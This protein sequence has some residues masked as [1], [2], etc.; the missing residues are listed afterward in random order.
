MKKLLGVTVLLALFIA[1]VPVHAN[2]AF[3][4][5][6]DP[7]T[8][9]GPFQTGL[10]NGCEQ[11]SFRNANVGA[12]GAYALAERWYSF[13]T[14]STVVGHETV[15][16]IWLARNSAQVGFAVVDIL[17]A[18]RPLLDD[19][20]SLI[21]YLDPAWSPN[22]KY[23]A[24][25]QSDGTLTSSSIYIQEYMVSTTSSVAATAVGSP[26]LVVAAAPGVINRSPD[27]K[28]TGA[29]ST[30][31]ALCYASNAAGPSFDIW[32][33]AVDPVAHTVGVPA[34]ATTLDTKGEINPSWG[35]G[36]QIAYATNKFGRNVIEIIDMDDMSVRLAETNFA[37]VSHNNPSWTSD[38]ASILYDA[39]QG[40]D[41]N[42]N[43]DIWKLDLTTQAKCDIFFDFRGDADPDV[44]AQTNTTPDGINYNVFLTSTQ[45]A[46]FGLCVWRGN[47]LACAPPL[48]L[49]VNISPTTLNLSSSGQNFTVTLTS[50]PE[51]QAVGIVAAVDLDEVGN[52]IPAGFEGIKNRNTTIVSP[53]F[54]GTKLADSEANG[55]PFGGPIYNRSNGSNLSV[56]MTFGRKPIAAKLAA[57]GIVNQTIFCPVTAYS[58]LR[59]RQLVGTG[60]LHVSSNNAA[61]Q[62]IRMEQNS[63]NPFNPVTKIRFAVAKPGF[64]NV[65]IY[66]VRGELV[67]TV[68][69]GNYPT[70]SHEATWD[71]STRSGAKAATGI[72]FAKASVGDGKGGEITSD[73]VKMVMVK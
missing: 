45:G 12:N 3:R 72:Y 52:G 39:P 63:P 73:F 27:W 53:T 70:G 26:L 67:K 31:M 18:R 50:P 13:S 24:Y 42:Q 47:P 71:G 16:S 48:Q 51:T 55:S 20:A 65:R 44:S 56:D 10:A 37:S 1:L 38:G 21:S 69:S 30:G 29:D 9:G 17:D 7:L 54:L 15:R 34:R 68:A 59:G 41:V 25:V 23:L 46:G 40:E 4:G 14:R 58:S 28:P 8:N 6:W 11:P 64:V 5:V 43:T 32:T 19:P 57:L 2:A 22:G 33:V 61:G 36:N 66:N 49:G 62:V 35:P 60:L